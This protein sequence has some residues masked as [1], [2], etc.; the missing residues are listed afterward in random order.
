[1]RKRVLLPNGKFIDFKGKREVQKIIPEAKKIAERKAVENVADKHG[2]DASNPAEGKLSEK[3]VELLRAGKMNLMA[4][5]SLANNR[6]IEIP[7]EIEGLEGIVAHILDTIGEVATTPGLSKDDTHTIKKMS[8]PEMRAHAK[9]NKIKIPAKCKKA[10]A[11]RDFLLGEEEKSVE[12][13][14]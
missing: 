14:L 11:I 3:D 4:V 7:D 2:F 13:E 12:D 8:I 10:D 1:M 6:K 5:V 9:K